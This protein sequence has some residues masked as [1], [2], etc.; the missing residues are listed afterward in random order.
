MSRTA[1]EVGGAACPECGE[2]VVRLRGG[3]CLECWYRSEER[4]KPVRDRFR[5]L[6]EIRDRGIEPYA[7]DFDRDTG[8]EEAR[9]RYLELNRGR[10]EDEE[11]ECSEVSIA[12]RVRSIRNFGGS[13]FAHLA[14]REGRLQI[15]VKQ[16]VVDPEGEELMEL[17]DLGD[18]GGVRGPL[19][20]T[21]T[22]EVTVRARELRLLSK[23]LRPLPYGKEETD[24]EGERVAM[25]KFVYYNNDSTPQGNPSNA[26][27]YY[28]YLRGVWRDGESIERD[29]GVHVALFVLPQD[30]LAVVQELFD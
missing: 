19:F 10:D 24:E 30:G 29:V 15:Y 7:Y 1:T 21:N 9:E 22:G 5:T 27:E 3:V 6:E 23:T 14:D 28:G 12:G 8:L 4:P 20:R 16:D 2:E 18:W 17:L 13:M 26:Q 11:E 25:A